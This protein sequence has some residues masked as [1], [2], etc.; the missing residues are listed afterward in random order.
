MKRFFRYSLPAT[1]AATLAASVLAFGQAA[2]TTLEAAKQ[3]QS[4]ANAVVVADESALTSA[5][6]SAAAAAQVVKDIE[7][8][9]PSKEEP[10]KEEPPASEILFRGDGSAPLDTQ[11]ASMAAGVSGGPWCGHNTS[12]TNIPNARF[13]FGPMS[14]MPKGTALHDW[15]LP[16]DNCYATLGRTEIQTANPEKPGFTKGLYRNGDDI[17]V[18]FGFVY[19]SNVPVHDHAVCPRNAGTIFQLHDHGGVGASVAALALGSN[20][21]EHVGLTLWGD[22]FSSRFFTPSAG[23]LKP[24]T[25]YR[26]VLHVL[27]QEASTGVIEV[28]AGVGSETPA[29]YEKLTAVKTVNPAGSPE[30]IQLGLYRDTLCKGTPEQDWWDGGF[31]IATSRAAAEA[32]AF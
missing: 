26:L 2:P 7:A 3:A 10:P 28:F 18:A 17:W 1:L 6:A 16:G 21:G 5:K 29:L 20:G 25:L 9:A 32:A 19:D 27:L 30:H 31:T 12:P 8:E 15:L 13:G 11:W 24:L 22:Y 14:L 23:E 4:K